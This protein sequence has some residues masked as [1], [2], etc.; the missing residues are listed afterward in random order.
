MKLRRRLLLVISILTVL[1]GCELPPEP[2]MRIDEVSIIERGKYLYTIDAYDGP[3]KANYDTL[4]L[5]IDSMVQRGDTVF[6]TGVS[7]VSNDKDFMGNQ[8]SYELNIFKT[9]TQIWLKTQNQYIEKRVT[10]TS[11]FVFEFPL[12]PSHSYNDELCRYETHYVSNRSYTVGDSKHTGVWACTG[13]FVDSSTDTLKKHRS[14]ALLSKDHFLPELS[15]TQELNGVTRSR[16]IR[17]IAVVP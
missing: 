8:R 11:N 15:L 2:V 13:S 10:F 4:V 12:K 14:T 6:Y 9:P 17:L 7:Y 5:Q 1:A 3:F 16:N